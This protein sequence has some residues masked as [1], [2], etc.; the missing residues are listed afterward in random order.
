MRTMTLFASVLA[1]SAATLASADRP[2]L[3]KEEP[4]GRREKRSL[5]TLF[6]PASLP[7]KGVVPLFLHFHAAGWLAEVAAARD[8]DLAVIHMHLGSGSAVYGKP[9]AD[10]KRLK[11]LIA[12]AEKKSGR[13]F[14]LVGLTGWSAG[15]GAVRAILRV[16]EYY[17]QVRWVVLMDGLHAGY[18][19]A[20]KP[21]RKD[22]DCYLKLAK[23]AAAG[24]KRFV[25][26]HTKIVPGTY[27][28]TTET[29]D[30]L[31][32]EVG[33]KRGTATTDVGL[34]AETEVQAGGLTI[35]GC[36]GA[37]APDHVDHLHALPRLV[38]LVRA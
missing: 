32:A 5:G 2:R 34:A 21:L 23:D 10:P 33:G 12:E 35:L 22:L 17:E 13:V 7:A 15:Y 3:T 6:L 38:N 31:V 14:E 27:A 1:A 16:E 26:T 28:S 24:K 18:D 29:C 11:Q 19:D 4:P 9:F 20:K 25:A 30:A 8:G 36:P 37:A